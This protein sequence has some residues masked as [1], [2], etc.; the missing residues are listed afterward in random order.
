M[1]YPAPIEEKKPSFWRRPVPMWAFILLVVIFILILFVPAFFTP[2]PPTITEPLII[3]PDTR[4]MFINSN[5]TIVANFTVADINTTST[6]SAIATPTLFYFSNTTRVPTNGNITLAI[7]GVYIG[8]SFTAVS[9]GNTVSFQPG[10]NTLV[11]NIK[12]QNAKPGIYA[13]TVALTNE[14]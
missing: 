8:T 4:T 5:E 9:A 1:S 14:S 11:L 6:I 7:S 10:A 3:S 12:A 2:L 13:V